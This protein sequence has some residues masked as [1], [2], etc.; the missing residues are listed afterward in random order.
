MTRANLFFACLRRCTTID[1][2]QGRTIVT[3]PVA[4][5]QTVVGV[6]R[7]QADCKK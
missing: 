6:H 7:K 5:S 1:V 4:S 2:D 3:I